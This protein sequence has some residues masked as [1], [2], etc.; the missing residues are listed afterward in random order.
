[1][2]G[3]C[4]RAGESRLAQFFRRSVDQMKS[5]IL[6]SLLLMA[7]SSAHAEATKPGT[8]FVEKTV[9]EERLGPSATAP[10][11]NR[12]YRTQKVEVFEVKDGWARVSKYDDGAVEGLSGQVARWVLADGLSATKPADLPQPSLPSDPRISKD[13]FPKIGESGLTEKD[14]L[15]LHQGA[16]KLLNSGRCSRVE[17]GDKS[18]SKPDTYYVNCAG[19]KNIFFT[20]SDVR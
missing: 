2:A 13:A 10:L 17:L 14:L 4:G 20:P 15:I 6:A 18:V 11:T 3:D 5:L 8:Y 16:I 12:L 19:P 1:M 9:L 7:W